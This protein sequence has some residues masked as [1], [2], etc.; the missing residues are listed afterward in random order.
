MAPAKGGWIRDRLL[1][2]ELISVNIEPSLVV[3]AASSTEKT[4]AQR[5]V[6]VC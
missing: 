2:P 5:E 1:K 6:T 4:N 3:V